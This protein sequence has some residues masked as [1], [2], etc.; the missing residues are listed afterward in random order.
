[1]LDV[2]CVAVLFRCVH[3]VVQVVYGMVSEGTLSTEDPRVQ[4]KIIH[5]MINMSTKQQLVGRE[6]RWPN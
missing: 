4:A 5:R 1:M 2:A 6:T 3:A